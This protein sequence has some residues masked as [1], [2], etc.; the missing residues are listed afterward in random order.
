MAPYLSVLSAK[1]DD[2]RFHIQAI[3]S[4][5][6]S[7]ENNSRLLSVDNN[8]IDNTAIIS[9]L[10]AKVDHNSSDISELSAKVDNTSTISEISDKVNHNTSDIYELSTKIKSLQSKF[11]EMNS[12]CDAMSVTFAKVTKDYE[13]VSK[14]SKDYEVAN[15]DYEGVAKRVADLEEMMNDHNEYLKVSDSIR[16]LESMMKDI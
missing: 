13:V 7:V 4:R 8:N 10:S 1:V 16:G 11:E 15:K 14:V 6:L 9:E 2:I 12:L 3:Y 5:I